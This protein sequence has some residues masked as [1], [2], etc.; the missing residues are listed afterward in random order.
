MNAPGCVLKSTKKV[1]VRG[2]YYRRTRPQQATEIDDIEASLAHL[3]NR[4][5][6]ALRA[7][8]A[9][10]QWTGERKAALAQLFGVQLI[11]GP[12]FFAA[13][14][15]IQREVLAEA[16]ASS[17]KPQLL[18]A[19]GGDVELARQ[20][21]TDI[22][23]G[24]T[25]RTVT[26][27]RYATK[28]SGIL[29]LMRWHILRFDG[30]WLAYSDH[31]V[32]LWPMNVERTLPFENPILGP[33]TMLEIRVPIAPDAAILMNWIDRSDVVDIT[34]KR[35][36]AA[37]LNAF[38]VSQADQEWMHKPGS[39][40][41]VGEGVFLPLSRRIDAS[42]NRAA[43]ERSARRSHAQKFFERT[44]KR[45]WVNELELIVDIQPGRPKQ[46]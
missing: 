36:V 26:M 39:E 5:T 16:E 31:P 14:E 4:A 40:A 15:D 43:A 10:E 18:D 2:P 27:L 21:V 29:A 22:L 24:S 32:V 11:R 9:G 7:V 34:M 8:I 37:E 25:N 12:A 19:V 38:T 41:E 46:R 30:P 3:E 13:H 33:L 6:P 42:Y 23:V 35:R 45:D 28:V 20:R 44:Q 1:G 17:F